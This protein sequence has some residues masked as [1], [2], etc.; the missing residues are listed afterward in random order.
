MSISLFSTFL[1]LYPYFFG[2]AGL[3]IRVCTRMELEDHFSVHHLAL[4]CK[5]RKWM[6]M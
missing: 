5:P 3:E 6:V 1:N 4:F 2:S